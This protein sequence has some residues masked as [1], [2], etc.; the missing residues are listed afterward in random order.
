VATDTDTSWHVDRRVN[1]GHLVTTAG[2]IVAAFMYATTIDKRVAVLEQYV[3]VQEKD[4]RRQDELS[5]Q[6]FSL[7]REDLREMRAEIVRL[8]DAVENRNRSTTPR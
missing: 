4:N 3:L 5:Q 1:I 2:F 8:R 7:I 6:T